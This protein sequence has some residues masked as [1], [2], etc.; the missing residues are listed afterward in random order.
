MMKCRLPGNNCID[1]GSIL[2]G[3]TYIGVVLRDIILL[4]RATGMVCS[5]HNGSTYN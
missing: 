1:I 2:L 4:C 3:C 5:V